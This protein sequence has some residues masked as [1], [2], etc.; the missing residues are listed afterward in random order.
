M[1]DGRWEAGRGEVGC[2]NRTQEQAGMG[3]RVGNGRWEAVH[4]EVVSHLRKQKEVGMGVR[5]GE[6]VVGKKGRG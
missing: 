6:G 2:N 3:R 5:T 4:K 1:E